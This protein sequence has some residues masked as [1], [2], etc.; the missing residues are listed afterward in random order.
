AG[1]LRLLPFSAAGPE[2]SPR[3]SELLCTVVASG[4]SQAEEFLRSYNNVPW[5]EVL[6][7]APVSIS[8]C[9][10]IRRCTGADPRASLELRPP[11][12]LPQGNVGTCRADV[13][14][15]IRSCR[16]P[17]SVVRRLGIVAPRSQVRSARSFANIPPP[18]C[19]A[20]REAAMRKPLLAVSGSGAED[21]HHSSSSVSPAPPAAGPHCNALY[22]ARVRQWSG[23]VAI[24]EE[25]DG[26][27]QGTGAAKGV[28]TFGY[29]YWGNRPTLQSPTAQ[30]GDLESA[31]LS[32]PLDSDEDDGVGEPIPKE[33][34][35]ERNDRLDSAAGYLYEDVVEH[36]WDKQDASGLVHYTDAAFWDRMAG[37]LDERCHDEWDVELEPRRLDRLHA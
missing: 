18:N 24:G 11:P 36:I 6:P 23:V 33:P 16:I 25:V 4:E 9:C 8:A 32:R 29:S 14:R 27:D 1:A 5:R 10:R 30:D 31:H 20:A 19:W 21:Q 7:D 12:A 22:R 26:I 15:A 35:Y 2:K 37:D 17:A 28:H 3:P 34:H 13:L